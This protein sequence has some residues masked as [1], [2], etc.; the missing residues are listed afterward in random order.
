M[1]DASWFV[2]AL[3]ASK[4]AGNRLWA[5]LLAWP[6]PVLALAAARLGIRA[7]AVE[8]S[9]EL[10]EHA[11]AAVREQGLGMVFNGRG[12]SPTSLFCRALQPEDASV[13]VV[14]AAP[15][16]SLIIGERYPRFL[17]AERADIVV[18]DPGAVGPLAKD[19]LETVWDAAERFLVP[20]GLIL[21][22]A[23]VVRAAPVEWFPHGS[24]LRDACCNGKGLASCAALSSRLFAGRHVPVSNYVRPRPL[25]RA[26]QVLRVACEWR[27]D[28]CPNDSA[29]VVVDRPGYLCGV[30]FWHEIICEQQGQDQDARNWATEQIA[31]DGAHPSADDFEVPSHAVVWF[32]PGAA[33]ARFVDLGQK[34]HLHAYFPAEAYELIVETI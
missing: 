1:A 34:L 26:S 25:A 12:F 23:V 13:H 10:R 17:D 19:F 16:T 11:A 31:P 32:S 27:L 22:R 28:K 33:A 24:Q 5:I 9:P 21:P 2:L 6:V 18:C 20:G 3:P 8:M 15:S 7:W 30:A 29:V 4:D 14:K